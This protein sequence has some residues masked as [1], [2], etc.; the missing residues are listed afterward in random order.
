[1]EGVWVEVWGGVC[2]G[3]RVWCVVC[4]G[5]RVCAWKCGGRDSV[6]VQVS[7]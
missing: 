7:G 2:G 1:M 5:R 4:G 3:V 6:H